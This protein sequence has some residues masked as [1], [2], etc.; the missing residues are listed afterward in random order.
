MTESEILELR[1]KLAA[2]E[3]GRFVAK[4]KLVWSEMKCQA[5]CA[6]IVE[7]LAQLRCRQETRGKT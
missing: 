1:A 6:Q 3:A 4:A 2:A 7:L 5:L